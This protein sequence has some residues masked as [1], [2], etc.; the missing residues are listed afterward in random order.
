MLEL[1][2]AVNIGRSCD[3]GS[4]ENSLHGLF[5]IKP[6]VVGDILLVERVGFGLQHGNAR[7]HHRGI[8]GLGRQRCDFELITT[9]SLQYGQSHLHG[10]MNIRMKP[11]EE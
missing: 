3:L 5:L 8:S 4:G 1:A 2:Q 11:L 9:K 6:R 7:S 10:G